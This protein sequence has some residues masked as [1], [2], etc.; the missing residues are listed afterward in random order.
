MTRIK[1]KERKHTKN[2]Y[3]VLADVSKC[4]ARPAQDL[5][6]FIERNN[7]QS[8]SFSV[9]DKLYRN[10]KGYGKE[11]IEGYCGHKNGIC[12]RTSITI[13]TICDFKDND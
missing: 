4:N 7:L 5:A 6:N 11:E 13:C 8:M 10:T 12:R 1:T 9:I 2:G 3:E